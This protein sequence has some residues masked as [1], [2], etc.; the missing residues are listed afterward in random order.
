MVESEKIIF[1]KEKFT[2]FFWTILLILLFSILLTD[3]GDPD[4]HLSIAASQGSCPVFIERF[5]VAMLGD[6]TSI[7][8]EMDFDIDHEIGYFNSS[9]KYLGVDSPEDVVWAHAINNR[10]LL[11]NAVHSCAHFIEADIVENKVAHRPNDSVNLSVDTLIKTIKNSGQGL[12]LDFKDAESIAPTIDKLIEFNFSAPVIL[13]FGLLPGPGTTKR[14]TDQEIQIFIEQAN[15]YPNSILSLSWFTGKHKTGHYDMQMIDEMSEFIRQNKLENRH[16]TF[17]TDLFY[18]EDSYPALVTL[19]ERF[20]G[21]TL[22][23]YYNGDGTSRR[24]NKAI[25]ALSQPPFVGKVFLDF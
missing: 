17:A 9:L 3:E 23:V 19:L 21:S 11:K 1:L 12:K 2:D 18:L 20:P 24:A 4:F 6:D 22:S 14:A 15:R 25:E 7:L 16:L 5:A 8:E 10:F 13:N